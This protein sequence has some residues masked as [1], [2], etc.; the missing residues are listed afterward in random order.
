M[1]D[2]FKLAPIPEMA[3][4][5]MIHRL[6]DGEL[7][8]V[9]YLAKVLD[10]V[11]GVTKPLSAVGKRRFDLSC[12]YQSFAPVN[13]RW[14][15]IDLNTYDGAPD[16]EGCSTFIGRGPTEH[17]AKLELLELFA[18]HDQDLID[19]PQPAQRTKDVATGHEEPNDYV[20]VGSASDWENDE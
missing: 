18:E 6:V 1:S 14:S 10:R 11:A 5:S 8:H 3:S 9:E 2:D 20:T 19:N 16:S 17:D 13:Q 12:E 15:C 7:K 4:D